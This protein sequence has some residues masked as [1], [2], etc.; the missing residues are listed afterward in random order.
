MHL[1]YSILAAGI[2][3]ASAALPAS[4]MAA[5]AP[6]GFAVQT[7]VSGLN[8]P[9][10]FA[11]ASDGRIFVAEKTGAIRVIQNGQLVSTPVITLPDVNTYADR[12][13]E[14]IALDPNFAQNG[15]LYIAYTHENDPSNYTGNKTGRLVRVTVAGNTANINTELILLGSVGGDAAHPSC[16]NF[17]TSSD[18]IPSDASTHT[19]GVL[20]FGPDGKLYASLGDGAGYLS[21]DPL[22][23]DAQD[24]NSLGGKIVR[25]NTDGTAPADNPFYTGNPNDN[26]S[27]VWAMG[28]RNAYR[29]N[30]RSDGT[31]YF[32]D[33][34]WAT[35]EEIDVGHA[36]ANYGWP[37]REGLVATSYN[38]TPSSTPTDP[39]YVY[40][41]SS[42]HGS[43]MGG[44]FGV[45][46]FAGDYFF[47]DYSNDYIKRM[48]LSGNTETSVNN[49]I[50]TAGG[51]VDIQT[52]PDGNLYYAAINVGE[53]RKVVQSGTIGGGNVP[54]TPQ[55]HLV[56]AT[57]SPTSP[58][59]GAASTITASVT[60]TGTSS[61][62][63][64][65][66]EVVSANAPLTLL[67]QKIY[68]PATVATGA[69]QQFA[70]QWTPS[71]AGNYI[72]KVGLFA[73]GWS[74]VYEWDEPA[75]SVTVAAAAG[76]GGGG[77]GGTG[78]VNPHF[79]SATQAPQNPTAG[80]QQTLTATVN[81]TGGT[82]SFIAD[83]EVYDSN[84]HQVAQKFYDQSVAGGASQQF[85]L[86]WT[87]S[88]AGTYTLKVGLFSEGW[89][90]VL[91]WTDQ[92]ATIT[93]GAG[94]GGG[95]GGTGGTPTPHFVSATAN[96]TQGTVGTPETLS[97]TIS[98]SGGTS[99]FV[100]DLEV[101]DSGGHLVAQKFYDQGIATGGSQNF[102]VTWTPSANGVYTLKVGL[103]TEG[104]T[105]LIEWTNQAVQVGVGMSTSVNFSIGTVTASPNPVSLGGTEH[106]TVSVTNHGAAGDMLL[107]IEVVKIPYLFGQDIIENQ[108]F[109]AGQTRTFTYDFPVPVQGQYGVPSDGTYQV[110]VGVMHTD[111]SAA[112]AW[113]DNA[114]S[115]VAQ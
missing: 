58:T 8:Q 20:R 14:G 34:G 30:F 18:C 105:Q 43:V 35:W 81:N 23:L 94:G 109:D 80:T 10:S 53:L 52:G 108:H 51:P 48:T 54:A 63:I 49:F 32:G 70:M 103:F 83:L 67:A 36:G 42:G 57:I 33:V 9:T 90:S 50:T 45:N 22:A 79:V 69:T 41:H 65:D 74:S 37:C 71:T 1:K 102:A 26:K 91:Q 56:S 40:D 47:G 82:G 4:A 77:G 12:G 60:N 99:N 110:D 87:P 104:W 101:Y 84:G 62:F 16:R 114:A 97:A 64:V 113:T 96:P 6:T 76:G 15:Y 100:T 86:A 2:M 19:M 66:I 107:D 61:P 72:V 115:F 5:T 17:A 92:A 21:V 85:T 3:L 68:D 95:G 112:Y 78:A 7:V 89:A 93:V 111:F 73:E 75:L 24:I 98:N 11:F 38:C 106:I 31:M 13:I 28:L 59:A 25:I 55:P 88:V 44:S 29:L 46:Y 39:I 27:K